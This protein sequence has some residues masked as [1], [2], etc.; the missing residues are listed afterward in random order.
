MSWLQKTGQ[1]YGWFAEFYFI[2]IP[3]AIVLCLLA[4]W[5]T[6]GKRSIRSEA[7]SLSIAIPFGCVAYGTLVI[8]VSTCFFSLP[9]NPERIAR[10]SQIYPM[11]NGYTLGMSDEGKNCYI[12][13]RNSG[14]ASHAPYR[15][16]VTAMQVEGDL[17]L[18]RSDLTT[19]AH[20]HYFLLDT[21]AERLTEFGDS[22][23]LRE[24]AE[25]RRIVLKLSSPEQYVQDKMH[26]QE[27]V[28]D[29]R[30]VW[31]YPLLLIPMVVAVGGWVLRLWRMSRP[32]RIAVEIG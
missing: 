28:Y 29:K 25:K 9:I 26:S 14:N 21:K 32:L 4:V 11:M 3:V 23:A 17:V 20:Q 31:L 24:A 27:K 10:D 16:R 2:A 18:G 13:K 8:M 12:V 30:L 6:H 1:I 19:R 7:I 15:D 22:M 5:W